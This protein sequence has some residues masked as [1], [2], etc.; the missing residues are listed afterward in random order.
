E[1]SK[2]LEGLAKLSG[3]GGDSGPSW[4]DAQS[5]GPASTEPGLDTADWFDSNLP[6]AAEQP[7]AAIIH[8]SD[9]DADTREAH[10]GLPPLSRP[11][12]PPLPSVPPISAL[13]PDAGQLP[14]A[15]PE[16]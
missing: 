16:A 12:V 3:P 5:T 6:P 14:P 13:K 11:V 10:S 1:F 9:E 15:P 8:G 2:A 4:L 7:E